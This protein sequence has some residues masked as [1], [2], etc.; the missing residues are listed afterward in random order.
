MPGGD[1]MIVEGL[2]D[3]T[4]RMGSDGGNGEN[5]YDGDYGHDVSVFFDAFYDTILKADL[6]YA[7][8][9]DLNGNY[10]MD[11]LVNPNGGSI[12]L[13]AHGGGRWQWW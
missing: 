2:Q 7:S 13:Y 5:G 11:Y 12:V 9:E 10:K 8:V 6:C 4:E 3:M 1:G